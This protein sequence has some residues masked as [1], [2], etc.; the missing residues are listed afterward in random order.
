LRRDGVVADLL[1]QDA[2]VVGELGLGERRLSKGS[3]MGFGR[4]ALG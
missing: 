2:G 4:S 1:D 3:K